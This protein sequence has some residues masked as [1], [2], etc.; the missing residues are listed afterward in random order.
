MAARVAVI[1]GASQGIG[2]A[3]ARALAARGEA[4]VVN[5]LA[6]QADT[7]NALA[8]CEAIL[9]AGGRALPVPGDVRRYEDVEALLRAA[10]GEFGRLD[11]WVNNAGITRD[12]SLHKMSL[13][14]WRQVIEVNLTGT[15]HGLKAASAYLR[16]RDWGRIVNIASVSACVP[17]WGQANYAASKA[18]VA[19]MTRVA[20]LELASRRIT[21]NAVAPGVVETEM[22]AAMTEEARAELVAKIPFGRMAR[23]EEVAEVVTFLASDA[24]SYVT[25]QMIQ[26]NGGVFMH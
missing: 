15:F 17:L 6:T 25:G 22:V 11:I 2:A 1:T 19:A 21:V 14:E 16:E 8:V 24:A 26:V 10:E 18:G 12:R 7:D 23:P 20:A 3:I 9:A 5:H 4:V 13:E